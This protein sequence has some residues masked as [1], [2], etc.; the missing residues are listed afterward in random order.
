MILDSFIRRSAIID[1]ASLSN[2]GLHIHDITMCCIEMFGF[3]SDEGFM[4][5]IKSLGILHKHAQYGAEGKT[6]SSLL[7]ALYMFNCSHHNETLHAETTR[8]LLGEPVSLIPFSHCTFKIWKL[9][10]WRGHFLFFIKTFY[11]ALMLVLFP[12]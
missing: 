5:L 6:L 11:G 10:C 12:N 9:Y 2:S 1:L 4:L 8:Y 7:K 3:I